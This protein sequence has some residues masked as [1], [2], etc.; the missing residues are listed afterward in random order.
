MLTDEVVCREITKS[1]DP[2][3]PH[4]QALY[5]STQH[6]DERVPWAWVSGSL[7]NRSK[8]GGPTRHLML[9]EAG[10]QLAGF[11]MGVYLPGYGGYVSYLGV[12]PTHRGRGIGVALFESLFARFNFDAIHAA[13]P[14]PF[15]VWESK[16]PAADATETEQATWA[17]RLRLFGKV[18]ARRIDGVEL[19]TPNYTMPEK[20]G[21]VLQLFVK[22]MSWPAESLTPTRLKVIAEGVMSRVYKLDR[23][24]ELWQRTFGFEPEMSLGE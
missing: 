5:D 8:P 6:A 2:I 22:P 10:G 23:A 3:L 12:D 13:E 1:A 16:Q 15:A 21:P 18:G 9:A 7:N 14:L 24:D 19:H 11:V 4:I 17:A 20:P